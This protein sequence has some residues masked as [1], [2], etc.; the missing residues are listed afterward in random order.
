MDAMGYSIAGICRAGLTDALHARYS[1]PCATPPPPGSSGTTSARHAW[2]T[3]L[4]SQCQLIPPAT[5]CDDY[6][7]QAKT[8]GLADSAA[9]STPESIHSSSQSDADQQS[10]PAVSRIAAQ[11]TSSPSSQTERYGRGESNAAHRSVPS[12]SLGSASRH[13]RLQWQIWGTQMARQ[14]WGTQ[15][16]RRDS[17]VHSG[18]I[19][20][21][22]SLPLSYSYNV[23]GPLANH[24][25]DR[26]SRPD[27]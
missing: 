25:N 8:S 15:M 20:R 7:E 4:V 10:P 13:R 19:G 27:S 12:A 14:I 26:H 23:R 22:S 2:Q 16:T 3:V 21:H 18:H 6:D 9:P 17:P 24:S 11:S 1:L 5:A